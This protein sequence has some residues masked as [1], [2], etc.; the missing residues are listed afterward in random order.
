MQPWQPDE[1]YR[2]PPYGAPVPGYG[3]QYV[4]PTPRYAYASFWR[5]FFALMLDSILVGIAAISVIAI[6]WAVTGIELFDVNSGRN[7]FSISAENWPIAILT[8][9]YFVYLNGRGATVGKMALGII[10][11]D[12]EGKA[13]GLRRGILRGIIPAVGSALDPILSL[14][15]RIANEIGGWDAA[16][17][18]GLIGISIVL[19]YSLFQIVDGLSMLGDDYRQTIHDKMGGTY[20][21]RDNS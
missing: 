4:L 16:L 8:T 7:S 9:A 14:V 11:T 10:V 6:L 5:R 18:T 20:V 12:R 15:T 1:S 21:I 2:Y 3:W 19:G 13:P 17:T